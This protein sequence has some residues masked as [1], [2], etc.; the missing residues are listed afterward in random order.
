MIQT[1]H[2][3][4]NTCVLHCRLS[5]SYKKTFDSQ[6]KIT[7]YFTA[8]QHGVFSKTSGNRYVEFVSKVRNCS[9]RCLVN[10][11]CIHDMQFMHKHFSKSC[12]GVIQVCSS[13]SN[14]NGFNNFTCMSNCSGGLCFGLYRFEQDIKDFHRQVDSKVDVEQKMLK[15]HKN[16]DQKTLGQISNYVDWIKKVAQKNILAVRNIIN[17]KLSQ[18]LK[19]S[20]N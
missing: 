12:N 19:K 10:Q 20:D 5:F 13:K 2:D 18:K 9:H 14:C 4:I 1:C 8:N 3:E 17:K 16:D 7:G 6:G 11:K 15:L